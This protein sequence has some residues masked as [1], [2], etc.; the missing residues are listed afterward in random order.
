M[1]RKKESLYRKE[2]K[3]SLSCKYYVV[4]GGD[5][6]HERNT[7]QFLNNE[8]SHAP[9]HSGQF[10]YDYTPLFKFLLSKVGKDWD[11]VFSEANSRLDKQEPIFWMVAIH[12]HEKKDIIRCGES[13][14]Y[15]GLFVDEN[16]LLQKVNPVANVDHLKPAWFETISFNGEAV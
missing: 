8:A 1:N 3:V 2:N 16:G 12:A 9:M 5:F 10:G 4:K 13:S 15:S 6:R 11:E 7:K 14:Y